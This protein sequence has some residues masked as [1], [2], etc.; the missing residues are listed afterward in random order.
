MARQILDLKGLA[1]NPNF[2][3]TEHQIRK[4]IIRD[5][6]P[7]PHKKVGKRLLFD[8]ERVYRW[9]DALPGKDTSI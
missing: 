4:L 9:F 5:D 7:L 3:F 6:Y 8:L 1:E 2:P